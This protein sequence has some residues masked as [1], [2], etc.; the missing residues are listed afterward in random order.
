MCVLIIIL[1]EPSIAPKGVN[2]TRTSQ[3][4]MLVMWI[5]LS[6]TEARGF[7]SHYTISYS[8]VTSERKRQS[9]A[10]MPETVLGMDSNSATIDGLNPNTQ[11]EVGVSATNGADTSDLSATAAVSLFVGM[12]VS[13]ILQANTADTLFSKLELLVQ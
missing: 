10:P 8:P 11:Y 1:T 5:P 3:T 6:F 9:S 2:V 7:I 4:Q 13:S 12:L